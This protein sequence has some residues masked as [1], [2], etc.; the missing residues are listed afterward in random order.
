MKTILTLL[1]FLLP[2]IAH[3]DKKK[4]DKPAPTI[5]LVALK[6]ADNKPDLAVEKKLT[7]DFA[8]Q[9]R[10][11]L[12]PSA[13]AA[14]LVFV[15]FTEYDTYSAMSGAAAGGYGSVA[16]VQQTYLKTATAMLVPVAAWTE[17]KSDLEKLKERSIWRGNA[18]GGF[19]GAHITKLVK[20]F[21]EEMK[22]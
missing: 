12:A 16:G 21:H 9:K 20:K 22:R 5:Y 8:K 3:D 4:D 19:Y 2:A 14:E 11:S 6:I 1:L 15:V 17:H 13:A 18:P 10:Y 7:E